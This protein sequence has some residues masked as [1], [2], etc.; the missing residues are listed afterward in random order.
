[1]QMSWFRETK[2]I[3]QWKPDTG[4]A[5][6]KPKTKHKPTAGRRLRTPSNRPGGGRGG[7]GS[8]SSENTADRSRRENRFKTR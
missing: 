8:H 2:H 1:M 4:G 5:E 7:G 6:K 3:P